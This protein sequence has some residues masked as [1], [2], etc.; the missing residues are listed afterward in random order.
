MPSLQDRLA[1]E[2]PVYTFSNGLICRLKHKSDLTYRQIL[3]IAGGL[4]ANPL[5]VLA[6]IVYDPF[7]PDPLKSDVVKAW[8][9][10]HE[11]ILAQTPNEQPIS[12]RPPLEL[13]H[14]IPYLQFHYG[15]LGSL[16][17]MDV[18]SWEVDMYVSSLPSLLATETLRAVE[19]VSLGSGMTKRTAARKRL[20]ELQGKSRQTE[21]QRHAIKSKNEEE[22]K[23][24]LA[25]MGVGF[26][27]LPN[28]NNNQ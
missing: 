10:F 14:V 23:L 7:P 24:R 25:M 1:V 28:P 3:T 20:R 6:A 12:D 18:P 26:V 15:A 9:I 16:D 2:R 8:N 4:N 27:K 22:H 11:S 13:G 21:G 19:A 5:S 17:W